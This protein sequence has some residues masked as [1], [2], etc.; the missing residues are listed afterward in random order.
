MRESANELEA[1]RSSSTTLPLGCDRP[2]IYFQFTE[3]R[4]FLFEVVVIDKGTQ[5]CHGGFKVNG[6]HRSPTCV[7]PDGW[8]FKKVLNEKYKL[9]PKI[10]SE[11]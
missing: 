6:I 7:A 9:A 11:Q 5:Y 10:L 1:V 8:T 2:S 3:R 4:R